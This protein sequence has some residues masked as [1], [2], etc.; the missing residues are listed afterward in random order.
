MKQAR[1]RAI[2]ASFLTIFHAWHGV[3]LDLN[4]DPYEVRELGK[5]GRNVAKLWANAAFGAGKPLGRWPSDLVKDY[6]KDHPKAPFNS[7]RYTVSR[8]RESLVAKYPLL[9]GWGEPIS[10]RA[11]TWADF[12]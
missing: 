4:K 1:A 12:R 10:G 11:R 2:R 8:V 7:K 5:G 3:Q 9:A 6:N